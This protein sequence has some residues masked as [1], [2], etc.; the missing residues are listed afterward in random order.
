MKKSEITLRELAEAAGVSTMT[1]SRALNGHRYVRKELREKIVQLADEMGYRPDPEFRKLMQYLR[2]NRRNRLRGGICALE[3]DKWRGDSNAYC[4]KLLQGAKTA[5]GKLGYVWHTLSWEELLNRPK[6]FERKLIQRGI[7]GIIIPPYPKKVEIPDGIDWDAF[8]VVSTSFSL[9]NP[10][11]T[12]VIPNHFRNMLTI[13]ENLHKRGYERL[14]HFRIDDYVRAQLQFYA[15]IVGFSVEMGLKVLP[16][17]VAKEGQYNSNEVK[18]WFQKVSPDAL[19]VNGDYTA[20]LISN[21]LN[22]TYPGDT[23][24][25]SLDCLSGEWAGINQQPDAIGA[26]AIESLSGMIIHGERGLPAR[27]KVVN[28]EGEWQDGRNFSA[29]GN[30]QNSVFKV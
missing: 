29:K 25:V 24:M 6:S 2:R 8:S 19:I 14:G 21:D 10:V 16:P 7:D 20:S 1:V 17:H 15:A 23:A 11:F 28:L 30:I 4:A 26:L 13:C 18:R 9:I 12:R 5:A 27:P 22:L 3:T